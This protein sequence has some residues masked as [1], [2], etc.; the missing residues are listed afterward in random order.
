MTIMLSLISTHPKVFNFFNQSQNVIS[1]YKMI[2]IDLY[3]RT[4]M[5]VTFRDYNGKF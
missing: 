4:R 1:F 3:L 5:S 2:V